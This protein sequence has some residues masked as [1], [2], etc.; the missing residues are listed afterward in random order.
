MYFHL[1]FHFWFYFLPTVLSKSNWY[2]ITDIYSANF[3]SFPIHIPF[4]SADALNTKT[5]FSRVKDKLCISSVRPL[6]GLIIYIYLD[7]KMM[8]IVTV[9]YLTGIVV[10][11]WSEWRWWWWA[12]RDWIDDSGNDNNNEAAND[13]I[14]GEEGVA[15]LGLLNLV[16]D[17][18]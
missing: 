14:W 15:A 1:Y 3:W 5:Q 8:I 6:C 17:F 18:I 7:R 10:T 9:I 13:C 4:P 16:C 11:A 12:L 2:D